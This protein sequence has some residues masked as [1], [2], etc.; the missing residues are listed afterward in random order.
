MIKRKYYSPTPKLLLGVGS[1]FILAMLIL[2]AEQIVTFFLRLFGKGAANY[3]IAIIS[4]LSVACIVFVVAIIELI[5]R[6]D[7]R[8]I[9]YLLQQRFCEVKYG[10]P[11]NLKEGQYLPV[12]KVFEHPKGYIIRISCKS[13]KFSDMLNLDK[14]ISSYL[15]KRFKDF[16]VI[17]KNPDIACNYVEYIIQDVVS[18]ANKQS[19]Y[20]SIE[21]IPSNEVTKRYIRDDVYLDISKV[22][23]ASALIVGRTRSGKT[24]GVISTLIFPTLIQGPDKF[25]SSVT[26]IDPK[27]AELSRCPYV[28]SPDMNGSAAEILK[29]VESFNNIRVK[30]QKIINQHEGSAKWF[31]IGMKPSILFIDEFVSFLDLFPVKPLKDNPHY[32][33]SYIQSLLQQIATMGASVGCFLIISVAE[34]SVGA[35]GIPSIINNACGI[36]ILFKPSISE[37]KYL[38]SSD[39]LESMQEREFLPGDT[40][41]S[42]DDGINNNV[43]FIKFPRLEFNEFEALSDLLIKYYKGN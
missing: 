13:A 12:I 18:N 29:A 27:S 10:N 17:S 38:W 16:A 5:F 1:L 41:W 3:K 21:D 7:R 2:L 23:N 37:A 25:F 26:I 34:A 24:T 11:L 19:I 30:R 32:C 14:V 9:L 42:S 20:R 43:S 22:L 33:L 31:K 8:K 39:K 36:R 4:L 15:S 35:G 6:S 28:L 40:W